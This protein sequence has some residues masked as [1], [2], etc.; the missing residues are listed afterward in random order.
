M[1]LRRQSIF[2]DM[3]TRSYNLEEKKKEA[4]KF[5]E[6]FGRGEW[7]DGHLMTEIGHIEGQQSGKGQLQ[8]RAWL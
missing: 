3:I 7:A 2:Q 6:K 8:Y 4:F 1:S 5:G